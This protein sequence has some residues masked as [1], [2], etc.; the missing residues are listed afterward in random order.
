M[1]DH[2][3][4]NGNRDSV[5]E[6]CAELYIEQPKLSRHLA[7]LRRAGLAEAMVQGPWRA[8]SLPKKFDRVFHS[9]D[10]LHRHLLDRY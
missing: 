5:L 4:G 2:L 9:L 1:I 3:R 8:Y 6:M 7:Y 10:V